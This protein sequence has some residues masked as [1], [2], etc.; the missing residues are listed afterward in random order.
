[1]DRAQG[2][3][4]GAD[5]YLTE[6]VE[7]DELLATVAALLRYYRARAEAERLA[8]LLTK[9]NGATL[10]MNAA[11]SIDELTTVLARAASDI[12]AVPAVALVGE[13]D[14]TL[15]RT[16][17]GDAGDGQPHTDVAPAGLLSGFDVPTAFNRVRDTSLLHAPWGSVA[18]KDEVPDA[19]ATLCLRTRPGRP[20]VCVA[21]RRDGLSTVEKSVLAQLGNAAMLTL[22]TLRI[23][24]E[25]HSLALTLQRSFLPEDVPLVEGLRTAVRYVPAARNAEIG[26]DFYELAELADGRLLVAIGDVA[27]HS[28]E[29]AIVMVE[30]RH[31]LRAFATEDYSPRTL[32]EK[33]DVVLRRYH[34]W[35]F[36]TV[37]L[38]LIDRERC[39]AE[40]VNAG[41]VP[42]LLVTPDSIGYLDV[43]GPMLGL[44]LP[45]PEA[46]R[47]PLPPA[48]EI[49]LTTDGL[50]E[51]RIHDLDYGMDALRDA[52]SFDMAPGEVCDRLIEQLGRN[53]ADDL[54]LLVLRHNPLDS[55]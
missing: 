30:I 15:C 39:S 3:N 47:V 2:L 33:L 18:P 52:V 12:F 7:A 36:V 14:A 4:Q 38:L 10:T 31:A 54:A 43:R 34:R 45:Q 19:S 24:I 28:I 46:T 35:N 29:A 11:T 23:Q 1:V 6:P 8:E 27:G 49:I 40:V 50:I 22:D 17:V 20:P 32:L 25:E 55:D 53:K 41:H 42:P 37:C 5:A 16:L 51:D 26:G 9:L 48:W 44:G 21:I 13:L